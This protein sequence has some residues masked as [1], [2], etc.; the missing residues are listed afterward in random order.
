MRLLRT[1]TP[2]KARYPVSYKLK[3]ACG[4]IKSF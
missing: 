3:C 1:L 2:C 4:T